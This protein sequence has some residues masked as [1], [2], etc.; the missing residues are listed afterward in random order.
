MK[1]FD[2]LSVVPLNETEW[3]NNVQYWIQEHCHQKP[4]VAE[5]VV[6]FFAKAFSHTRCPRHAW[7]GVHK[8]AISLVVGG[9]WLAAVCRSSKDK[10]AWLL[11]DQ[12]QPAIEGIEYEPVPST[13]ASS[14][15][16]IWA[17]A[18][19]LEMVS[20]LVTHNSIWNAYAV[21][22]E[23]IFD[24]PRISANRDAW[25]IKQKKKRLSEFWQTYQP[26]VDRIEGNQEHLFPDEV[27]SSQFFYE[28]SVRQVSVNTYER[29][30]TARAKCIAHHGTSCVV[31]D[32]NFETTYGEVGEGFI[33]VHH[34][35]PL[36]E[37]GEEY[38]VDPIADLRP[39]C[40]NCHAI[41]HRRNPPYTIEEIQKIVNRNTKQ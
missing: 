17:H 26:S 24:S 28:G 37:I 36:R 4:N 21:A 34:L 38:K 12:G 35:R 23:K 22:S 19:S 13:Q 31:C 9:L 30:S 8:S 16:L 20:N 29:N 1:H 33:H 11:L 3:Q 25:Q 27:R 18:S 6:T 32:F 15:P 7:F 10:G 40:P 5:S 14:S 2:N 41:I 39:V